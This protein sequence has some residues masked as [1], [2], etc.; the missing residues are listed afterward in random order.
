MKLAG[1]R[2]FLFNPL[3][4][5]RSIKVKWIEVARITREILL[6]VIVFNGTC[7]Q[8]AGRV[9][10][11]QRQECSR[12]YCVIRRAHHVGGVFYLGES[13]GLP[14]GIHAVADTNG[15]LFVVFPPISVLPCQWQR[16]K[17]LRIA[18]RCI[19]PGAPP[20]N[21]FT[22]NIKSLFCIPNGGRYETGP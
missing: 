8:S 17:L 15:I 16:V 9:R 14:I 4:G 2:K 20:P 21:P 18:E 11:G 7:E 12:S 19:N 22:K 5:M 13:P 10:N 6:D 1:V 3:I